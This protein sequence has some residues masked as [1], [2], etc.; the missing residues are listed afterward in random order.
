[1]L[2]MAAHYCDYTKTQGVVH[3]NMVKMINI[4]LCEYLIIEKCCLYYY[5]SLYPLECLS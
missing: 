5:S 2:V 4:M 3:F 1:M